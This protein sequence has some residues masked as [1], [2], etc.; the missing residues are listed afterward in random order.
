MEQDAHASELQHGHEVLDVP[1]PARDEPPRVVQPGKELFDDP[2]LL[3]A[4]GRPAVLRRT[5]AVVPMRGDE[6]Y[7]KARPQGWVQ[8]VT[9]VRPISNQARQAGRDEPVLERGVDEPNFM[10]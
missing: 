3:V 6:L 9:V 7:P 5:G 8:E 10:W 1:L 4:S 2:A